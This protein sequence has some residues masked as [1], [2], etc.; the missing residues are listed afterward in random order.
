MLSPQQNE[1]AKRKL[2]CWTTPKNRDDTPEK[3]MNHTVDIPV[4]ATSTSID[5][6]SIHGDFN[7][8]PTAGG[9][10]TLMLSGSPQYVDTAGK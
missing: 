1:S 6:T 2:V 4:D 10:L 8:T 9:K 3:A 7:F 5:V